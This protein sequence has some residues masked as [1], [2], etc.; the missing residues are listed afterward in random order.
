M[1][2]D[3]LGVNTGK[4]GACHLDA[5]AIGSENLAAPVDCIRLVADTT[6]VG[7]MEAV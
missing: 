1:G 4:A 5:F 3:N 6:V 7:P 2:I